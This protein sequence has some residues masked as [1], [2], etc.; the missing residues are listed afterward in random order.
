MAR[1]SP[2]GSLYDYQDGHE[3]DDDWYEFL[4]LRKPKTNIDIDSIV[5]TLT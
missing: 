1:I 5:T 3:V 2:I 4:K